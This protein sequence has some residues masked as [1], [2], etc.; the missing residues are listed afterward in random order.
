MG[1][2]IPESSIS[3]PP[4][5]ELRPNQ[6]DQDSLPPYHVLDEI[7]ERY[8]ERHEPA[9]LIAASMRGAGAATVGRVIRMIDLA[10]FKRKQAPIGLKVTGVAFGSGRRHPIAQGWRPDL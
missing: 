5:A 6:T 8:V 10:E 1:P 4:S 2:P 9:A 3:K 7:I